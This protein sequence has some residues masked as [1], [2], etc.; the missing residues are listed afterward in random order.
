MITL[1]SRTQER[2]KEMKIARRV[3]R[4]KRFDGDKDVRLVRKGNRY[5][6][7]FWNGCKYPYRV[8]VDV[9]NVVHGLIAFNACSVSHL[10]QGFE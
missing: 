2:G 4:F 1:N 10:L 8:N 3:L 7:S 5:F 9:K 6:L